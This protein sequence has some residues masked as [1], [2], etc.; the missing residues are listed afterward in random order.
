MTSKFSFI[1]I[2]AVAKYNRF[3]AVDDAKEV[4]SASGGWVTDYRMFSN[5]S[6]CLCF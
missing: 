4:I 3:D 6:I 5:R 1:R 2:N